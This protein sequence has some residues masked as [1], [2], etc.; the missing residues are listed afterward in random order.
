MP[1]LEIIELT[2]IRT[3]ANDGAS[4]PTHTPADPFGIDDPC[5][6]NAGGPHCDVVECHFIAC[7]RCTRIIWT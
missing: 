7:A 3:F 4:L 5:P 6:A 1:V 2:T